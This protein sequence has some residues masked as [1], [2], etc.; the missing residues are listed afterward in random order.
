MNSDWNR[1]YQWGVWVRKWER[2]VDVV[3]Q[4]GE[5]TIAEDL[6]RIVNGINKDIAA[7]RE[8][9]TSHRRAALKLKRQLLNNRDLDTET[10]DAISDEDI[11]HREVAYN[12]SVELERL[13]NLQTMCCEL[14]PPRQAT[15]RLTDSA[16]LP[17]GKL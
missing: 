16:S 14:L 17:A 10:S 12:M 15:A 8:E 11:A 1:L 2:M 6:G 13:V 5:P 9:M 7:L 3:R 4:S